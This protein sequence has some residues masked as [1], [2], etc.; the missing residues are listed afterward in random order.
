VGDYGAANL[1]A[2][3][4]VLKMT[5]HLRT[6]DF[7]APTSVTYAPRSTGFES[8]TF[9]TMQE[10]GVGYEVVGA[11]ATGRMTFIRGQAGIAAFS[12]LGKIEAQTDLSLV[13]PTVL[14]TPQ[15]PKFADA[16]LTLNA[17][18]IRIQQLVFDLGVVVVPRAFQNDAKTVEGAFIAGR[19]PS[20]TV[21]AEM[22]TKAAFDW[23]GLMDAGTLMALTW[24]LG[25]LT[26]NR[27]IITAPKAQITAIT[28]GDRDGARI[29]NVTLA[30]REDAGNDEYSIF[31][32]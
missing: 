30:L 8:H 26:A 23:Y 11:F 24:R 18:A 29:L 16:A 17:V 5:G 1:P 10:F 13:T 28:E 6:D 31:F 3:D 22:T 9:Y 14:A 2:I 27:M 15:F 21:D 19:N 20:V 25:T 32:D 12:L 4:R 7:V